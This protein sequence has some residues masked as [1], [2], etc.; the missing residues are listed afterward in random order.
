MSEPTRIAVI[1]DDASVRRALERL[2]TAFG[3]VTT[4]YDS[5][6]DF[7]HA[8]AANEVD[9]IVAD[10]HLPRIN[11][12]QLQIQLK[13]LAP[14]A[15][16]VFI[17]GHGNLAIGMRAMKEGAVDF[18]E[19]PVDDEALIESVRSGAE[20]CRRERIERARKS[21]LESRFSNLSKREREVF[22]LITK[23]LL[24]K[25]VGYELGTTERTIK[26]HRARVTEKMGA[27]SLADLVRMAEVL[28]I[29][30]V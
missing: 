26:A 3:F 14:D 7:L 17:T 21:E 23:G 25:Q 13:Q 1:E 30:D 2:L 16:L 4:G 6:E 27:D 11:G 5:A 8:L 19:K 28:G 20:R 18:L 24:N 12:L 9:C 15:A 29:H 10:V 22:A